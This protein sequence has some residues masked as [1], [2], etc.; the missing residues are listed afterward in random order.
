MERTG[1]E[2]WKPREVARLLALVEAERRY[3]QE[4]TALLPIPLAVL[5]ADR[6]IVSANRAFRN[7]AQMRSEDLRNR[8]IEQV[9]PSDLLIE[10]L[11][12][13]HVH[14]DTEPFVL[15]VGQRLFRVAIVPIRAWEEDSEPETL[16]V[17]EDLTGLD[18]RVEPSALPAAAAPLGKEV[19]AI[20]WQASAS[21]LAFQ[22]AGG[23]V[24][25]ILGYP[26]SHWLS[27]PRFFSERIHAED[28]GEV[29][30]LYRGVL[31]SGGEA[32]AEFRAVP[33]SGEPVWCRETIHAPAPSANAARF[34]TGVLI[35]TGERRQLETLSRAAGRIEALRELSARLAHDFNNALMIVTGYAEEMANAL[36]AANPLRADLDQILAAAG[37]MAALGGQ[38]LSFTRSEARA[39][40]RIAL[41]PLLAGLEPRLR[42]AAGESIPVEVVPAAAAALAD[43][44]Q[45]EDA[46][47]ALASSAAKKTGRTERL[48]VTCGR[49]VIAERVERATL[50]PGAYARIEIHAAGTA[51][52]AASPSAA[53]AVFES[54]LAPKPAEKPPAVEGDGPALARAYLNV[55]D[56]GGDVLYSSDSRG[57]AFVVYLREA[58]PAAAARPVRAAEPPTILLAEDESGI[59]ALVVK[60]LRRERYR[61]LEAASGEEALAAAGAHT[62]RIDVLLSDVMLPGMS[63]RDLAAKLVAA[64]PDLRVVYIS[65]FTGDEALRTGAF[66]PGAAFLQKPF[67]LDS[68]MAKLREA[69]R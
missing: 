7:L 65:G 33:A 29:M 13:A 10:R 16:L 39:P 11:R 23:A 2:Q 28:R 3:Y 49:A 69:L 26:P 17:V 58:E 34:L 61:V 30:A 37:R 57:A 15:P 18:T 63:G 19:P 22:Y 54:F 1:F 55:R 41:G 38:L 21:T 52:A 24:E 4:I 67:T 51:G 47:L 56:W 62:G 53:Q 59:R 36:P 43:S 64:R 66:P 20:V 45:L 46:I 68:L 42:H 31:D 6:S 8:S 9:L 44:G 14:G 5:A 50:P 27:S 60:I 25:E 40:A 32:S 35:R 12:S 48:T